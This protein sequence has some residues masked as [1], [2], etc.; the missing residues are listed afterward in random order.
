M[1]ANDVR[2]IVFR[3]GYDDENGSFPF[4]HHQHKNHKHLHLDT[5]EIMIRANL[6]G[7]VVHQRVLDG[8]NCSEEEM[9]ILFMMEVEILLALLDLTTMVLELRQ[10]DDG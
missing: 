9:L 10:N 4:K 6:M 2:D 7:N 1:K 3:D 5:K 8:K